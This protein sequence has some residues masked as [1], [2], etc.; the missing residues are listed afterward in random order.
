M[1]DRFLRALIDTAAGMYRPA[2]PFAY[3]F[4]RG[5][6]RGD[7]IFREL[8]RQGLLPAQARII[9]LGCGQGLLAAWLLAARQLHARGNWPVDWPPP[10]RLTKFHGIELSPRDVSRAR[11]ALAVHGSAVEIIGGNIADSDFGHAGQV[12]IFDVLHYLAP[13]AQDEVLHRARATLPAGGRLLLRV[14]DAAAGLPFRLTTAV[15]LAISF[16][17][18]NRLRRL[19]GRPLRDWIAQ[20]ENLGFS[21]RHQPMNAG[22]PFANTLLIAQLPD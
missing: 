2:G 6:L 17:R 9:D 21:V 8:L 14:G 3:H 4:A 15:D 18:G 10:P 22:K 13:P 5:K 19:H 1:T 16:M 12:T 11:R 20:L 7:P